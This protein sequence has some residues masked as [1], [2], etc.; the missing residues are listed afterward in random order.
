MTSGY[1]TRHVSWKLR[2]I[3]KKNCKEFESYTCFTVVCFILFMQESDEGAETSTLELLSTC[4]LQG[5]GFHL[6]QGWS[7]CGACAIRGALAT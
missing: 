2:L 1:S 7:T 4:L 6:A 5:L 3:S